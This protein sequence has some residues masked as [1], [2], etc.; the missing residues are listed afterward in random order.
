VGTGMTTLVK[1]AVL[2][3]LFGAA[4]MLAA[5]LRGKRIGRVVPPELKRRWQVLAVL[6]VFF[7][8]GYLGFALLLVE[9]LTLSLELITGS[10]FVGGAFFVF[11]VINLTRDTVVRI[12]SAEEELIV[13]NESLE[14]RV[15]ER[16]REVQK[17]HTFLRTVLDSLNDEVLIIDVD[18]YKIQDAN[19]SFLLRYGF[20]LAEV[21]GRTCYELTH[22]RQD[23]CS[24]PDDI[25]P[26]GETIDTGRFSAVEHIHSGKNGRRIYAEVS[27]SP[28]RDQ[29]G[30]IRQVVHVTRDITMRKEAD[31]AL[32]RSEKR[33]RD[34]FD[35]TLDGIFQ[36]N[37]GGVFTLM[38]KSGAR[39]FGHESAEEMIGRN[40]LEYWREPKDR[41]IYREELI[42]KKVLSAYP[43]KA[44]KKSGEPIEL[45]SSSRIREDE[46]GKFLGIEGI[47]RDVT[48]RK[49]LEEE[50]RSLSLRDEL[51][52]LYNRRGFITL[53]TQELRMADR[54]KR[55]IFILYAD[56][57]G[58]KGI[59]DTM[60]HKE[61]DRAIKETADVLKKTF[62]NSDV[63]GRIGGDEFVIIPIGAAGDNIEIIT[64]RLQKNL[65][66]GNEQIGRRY[67]LS[68]SIGIAYYDPD[69]PVTIENLLTEADALMYDQKK[70]K[71]EK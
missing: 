27:T 57:D 34:L 29:D 11:I 61:G 12:R 24:P 66:T 59:N 39:I 70:A 7:L 56:L 26:L 19:E 38:N 10:I 41:E 28:I 5:I 71:R 36:V 63:I 67:K 35:S 47:L 51:T 3:V 48:E 6:M 23:V 68:L 40:A 25:C 64:D 45:E 69:N 44:R 42:M 22:N 50:L 43:M 49:R 37:A 4:L 2:L 55:G 58:L 9:R 1:A 18:T 60:G 54:L 46:K 30:S 15:V 17:S 32:R 33:Y 14:Q 62:R 20:T 53:A 52:G 21:V 13:I 16:T 8:A 65:D 31:E